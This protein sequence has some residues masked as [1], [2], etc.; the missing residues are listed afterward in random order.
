[1]RIT[2]NIS[3]PFH[4]LPTV[5]TAKRYK[6][7]FLRNFDLAIIFT[8]RTTNN[9][10]K[11]FDKLDRR[12]ILESVTRK[13]DSMNSVRGFDSNTTKRLGRTDEPLS[14]EYQYLELASVSDD[15]V[16]R[17]RPFPTLRVYRSTFLRSM[18]YLHWSK[19]KQREPQ[20][21]RMR[22]CFCMQQNCQIN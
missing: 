18:V 17:N 19:G 20:C 13:P 3:S 16:L 6:L 1:M 2:S 12:R 10:I 4:C 11:S 5:D 22:G 9:R 21:D 15:G 14:L 7:I 8:L